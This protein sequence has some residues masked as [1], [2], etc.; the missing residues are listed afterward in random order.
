MRSTPRR[1]AV[2]LV[3]E[4]AFWHGSFCISPSCSSWSV[5]RSSDYF[6]QRLEANCVASTVRAESANDWS[7]ILR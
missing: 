4:A 3:A 7:V 5:S 2:Q 1:W 6:C